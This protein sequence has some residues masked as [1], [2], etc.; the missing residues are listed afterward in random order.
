MAPAWELPAAAE[1]QISS[2]AVLH[3]CVSEHWPD[4]SCGAECR[5]SAAACVQGRRLNSGR[6]PQRGSSPSVTA[7]APLPMFNKL[8]LSKRYWGLHGLEATI[9]DDVH[10]WLESEHGAPISVLST[11]LNGVV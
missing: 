4:R 10:P 11:V 2:A 9:V 8:L 3:V 6:P 7:S 5:S 1:P